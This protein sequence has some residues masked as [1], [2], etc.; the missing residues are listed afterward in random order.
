MY[1]HA[2]T[3]VPE[4]TEQCFVNVQHGLLFLTAVP[5]QL[6]HI[7]KQT[8]EAPAK[9]LLSLS[10]VRID[11]SLPVQFRMQTRYVPGGFFNCV[12]QLHV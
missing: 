11:C 6:F 4:R 8:A 10:V 2:A 1:V 3:E 5:D 12:K 9:A 7:I